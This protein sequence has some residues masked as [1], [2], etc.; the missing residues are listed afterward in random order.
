M[1]S[2]SKGV[3]RLSIVPVRREPEDQSEILTQLLFGDH[4]SIVETDESGKWLKICIY[5]DNYLGWIDSKQ[6]TP[7]SF[8]YFVAA[9]F[10]EAVKF[11]SFFVEISSPFTRS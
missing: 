1:D 7:I 8:E 3:C 9:N 4:Y 6:N 5:L 2:I 10:F 11:D